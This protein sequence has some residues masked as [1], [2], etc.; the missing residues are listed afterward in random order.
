MFDKQMKD[1]IKTESD[2]ILKRVKDAI[3]IAKNESDKRHE[4]ESNEISKI[5][6]LFNLQASKNKE[7]SSMTT[8]SSVRVSMPEEVKTK[9]VEQKP[10]MPEPM[11]N[12]PEPKKNAPEP[13]KN[14][15]EPKKNAPESKGN[16]P[17]PRS[18]KTEKPV[19]SI[20]PKTQANAPTSKPKG[21]ILILFM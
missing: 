6:T 14:T 9:P 2:Y 4:V 15:P 12:A 3:D 17:D 19:S 20:P 7:S 1:A 8:D 16:A 10:K 5:K 13:K 18:T 11:K 21:N